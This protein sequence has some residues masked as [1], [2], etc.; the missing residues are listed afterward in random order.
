MTAI[1]GDVVATRKR[2]E[3]VDGQISV[4]PKLRCEDEARVTE[5]SVVETKRK[6]ERLAPLPA[7]FPAVL[8]VERKVSAQALVAYRGNFYSVPPELTGTAVTVARPCQMV[9]VRAR[10]PSLGRV[11][12]LGARCDCDR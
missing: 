5:D 12:Q 4:E 2:V 10:G 1:R 3:V 6:V 7:A 11:P 8:T 9:C